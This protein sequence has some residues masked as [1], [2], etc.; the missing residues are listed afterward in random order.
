MQKS[1]SIKELATALAKA[2]GEIKGAIKDAANPFFKSTYADLASCV[3]AIKVAFSKHGLSYVQISEPSEKPEVRIETVILHS[4]GEWL[5]CGVMALP[6]TKNDAQGFGSACT[7][8][9]RYSLCLVGVAPEDDDANAATNKPTKQPITP[10]A[11]AWEALNDQE[12][13]LLTDLS[14]V[15]MEAL[16]DGDAPQ[17]LKMIEDAGLDTDQSVALWTRFDSKQRAAM[18]K[19]AAAA[20]GE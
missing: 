15:A 10:T 14:I 2:Q 13:H 3:D 4:S 11:G 18:K 17:A 6:V 1:E 9:R 20:K 5:S 7:Y 19:A 8:A 16:A 12:R